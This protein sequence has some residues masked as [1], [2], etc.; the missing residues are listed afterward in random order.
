MKTFLKQMGQPIDRDSLHTILMD[1]AQVEQ[2]D[3]AIAASFPFLSFL[4]INVIFI[5]FSCGSVV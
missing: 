5:E 3:V 2:H 1:D 4:L